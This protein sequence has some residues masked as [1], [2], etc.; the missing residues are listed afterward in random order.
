MTV[1]YG[2]VCFFLCLMVSGLVSCRAEQVLKIRKTEAAQRLKEG[3]ISFILN[4][5]PISLSELRNLHPSAPF[6]GG[7]LVQATGLSLSGE[8]RETQGPRIYRNAQALFELALQS[9]SPQV[10]TAAAQELI[11]PLLEG[12]REGKQLARRITAHI[13]QLS[14]FPVQAQAPEETPG[15]SKS[16]GAQG[17]EFSLYGAALYILGRFDEAVSLLE[18]QETRSSWDKAIMLL[19]RLCLQDTQVKEEALDFLLTRTPDKPA[20]WAFKEMQ[21]RDPEFFTPRESAAIAGRLAVSRSSYGEGLQYFRHVLPEEP[22]LF[23]QY[24]ELTGDLGRSFQFTGSLDEGISLFRAWNALLA[25]EIQGEAGAREPDEGV[26]QK[27]FPEKEDLP[28]IDV[29]N[30]R[31]RLLYFAGRMERQRG[32]YSQAADYFK[33]ALSFAP[34]ALQ[35]D[36]CI[37][38]ILHAAVLNKP[39]EALALVDTYLPRW[40]EDRYFADILDLVCRYLTANRQW[41]G[42]LHLFSRIRSRSDGATTAKYAYILGRAV[43]ET[44]ISPEQAAATLGVMGMTGLEGDL[45]TR[46]TRTF[47][48]IAFEEKAASFY[49][50]AMSAFQLGEKGLLMPREALQTLNPETCSGDSLPGGNLEFLLHFFEFGAGKFAFS[51]LQTMMADFS[52]PELR[53]LA[54]AFGAAA[55]WEESIRI[56]TAY[57]N[58]ETY[59]LGY[60]DL[61][62]YYP[63][64]FREIIDATAQ[65]AGIPPEL[66]YALIRTESAFNPDIVSHAGAVGLSQLMS[67]T[68]WEVANRIRKEGGPNYI[69]DHTLDLRNPATNVHIGASYL[70]YL[71]DRLESPLQALLAYNGGMTRVKRWRTAEPLFPEDLFLETISIT[72]TRT[73]GKRVLAAAAA[74]GYLYFDLPIEAVVRN[75][76]KGLE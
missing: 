35:E 4:A 42:L 2:V 73:Y 41:D 51:Y 21:N 63:R 67:D 61:L 13:P 65:D 29:P 10:R 17:T 33:A 75:V 36:A 5:D 50:Q 26:I 48:K 37:W 3:D 74:Y 64:P 58:R 68:A 16:L 66:L 62:L 76:Y 60:G 56:I 27:A 47:F 11:I 23:L 43:A 54:E 57:M 14:A 71:I 9:S 70:R 15:I 49:Y 12:T 8:D 28:K 6:Y 69:T 32:R 44:S 40:H 18:R 7:L 72:E 34:D 1:G 31:Y 45:K 30:I 52:I 22:V 20:A 46:I 25:A 53:T 59:E 39:E 19:S 55:Y 24:P 38:Y